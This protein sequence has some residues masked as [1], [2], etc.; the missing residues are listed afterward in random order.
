MQQ[1]TQ[2]ITKEELIKRRKEE[3]F[4]RTCRENAMVA[5]NMLREQ[6]RNQHSQTKLWRDCTL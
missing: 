2:H 6:L 4:N 5:C 1:Q 3:A